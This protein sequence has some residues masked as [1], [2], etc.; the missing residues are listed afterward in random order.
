MGEGRLRGKVAIV[1]GGAQGIGGATARRLAAAGAAVLIVD[2]DGELGA[3]NAG[4]IAAAG[5]TASFLEGDVS[6]EETA[7]GMVEAAM[8]RCG[9]LDILVQNAFPVGASGLGGGALEVGIDAWRQGL[10]L[11]VGALYLGAKHAVPA[12]AASGPPAGFDAAS[13]GRIGLH[14]GPPPPMEV[15]RIVNMSSVHGLLQAAG[16]LIYEVGKAAVIGLTRQMAVDFGP[17][18]I[19]VNAIAPGH[20]VTEKLPRMWEEAG[21]EA[22][23]RL[24]E[25]QYPV[26]RTG[27]PD[28]IAHAVAFLC[29]PEASFITGV[30]LP[31]DGGL[32]VQLQENIVM[33]VKDYIGQHPEI[34][35]SFDRWGANRQRH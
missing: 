18:G 35:T 30:I 34:R 6:R 9:R 22:G 13:H 29:S 28:D 7:K 15:G 16:M 11:L 1:T 21:N 26:R 33:E 32:S 14:A 17:K 2:T 25:L 24:F 19:T 8:A 5:G 12:M 4:R 10:D 3:A 23:F 20:I 31:V 27:T